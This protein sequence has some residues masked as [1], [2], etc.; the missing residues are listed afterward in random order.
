MLVVG[1]GLSA[2]QALGE[3]VNKTDNEHDSPG[4]PDGRL[5]VSGSC[6]AAGHPVHFH[7]RDSPGKPNGRSG[8]SGSCRAAPRPLPRARNPVSQSTTTAHESVS[9]PRKAR[10]VYRSEPEF[11]VIGVVMESD[12]KSVGRVVR[13]HASAPIAGRFRARFKALSA[14]RT[15]CRFLAQASECLRFHQKLVIE[16]PGTMRATSP[17]LLQ[18]IYSGHTTN[19]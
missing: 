10:S 7:E 9:P 5:G 14:S 2:L 8:I 11:V 17:L 18:R 15:E 16:R 6:R 12:R 19:N 1:F 3:Q 4:K 13:S